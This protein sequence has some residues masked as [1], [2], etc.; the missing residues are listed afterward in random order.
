MPN[1]F[2]GPPGTA[3]EQPRNLDP[4]IELLARWM[5]SM[6]EIPGLGLR[7]G[8]DALVGLIPGLGDT[9]TS[10]ASL[11]ILNAA[12]RYGISRITML[13]MA[14][15]IAIDYLLGSIPLAG[16]AFDVYWKANLRNVALLRRHL[17][18]TPV[19][20][21]RARAGDWV[22]LIAIALGLA[23]ILAGS[24]TLS[25]FLVLSLWRTLRG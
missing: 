5:D 24:L 15:N 8:L 3:K 6:F 19:E 1:A 21:R 17:Q 14:L 22:F 18:A 12:R 7:F 20:E 4:D 11:Y 23:A 13:R 9:A 2:T 10:L 25:C 16:D